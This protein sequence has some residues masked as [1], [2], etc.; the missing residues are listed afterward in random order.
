MTKDSWN[1]AQYEKF[2]AQRSQPFY[3][4]MNLLRSQDGAK[5]V[6]LGCG[7]GELTEELHRFIRASET[8]GIDSSDEMLKKAQS[9]AGHGLSFQKGDIQNFFEPNGFDIIF[10]NAAIQWCSDHT[11]VFAQLKSSLRPGGQLAIQMPMNHDYATHTIAKQM[12]LKEPWASLMKEPYA[13]TQSMLTVEQYASLLFKLGF[14]E[15]NVSLKVYGHELESREGVIEWVKGTLLTYFESRLSP[16]DFQAFQTE[17]RKRL[18]AVLPDE[19]PFFY[20]FKRIL[21]W[22]QN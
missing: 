10:S 15:Q 19:K 4:L 2:K 5:V 22:A 9:F 7:T 16:T 8:L 13:K 6:D 12:S 20:P 1:P 17:F 3:D 14:K 11:T 18:F 21:I